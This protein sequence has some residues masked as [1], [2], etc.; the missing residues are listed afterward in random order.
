[1]QTIKMTE[2]NKEF[3]KVYAEK[4]TIGGF[5]N[6][7]KTDLQ[8]NSRLQY[9]MTGVYGELAFYTYRYGSTD[10][11][12]S[13]L[14]YKFE[15]LR[16]KNTGDGGMDDIVEIDGVKKLIDIKTS[17]VTDLNKIQYLNLIIPPREFH[18]N[19]IYVCAFTVGADRLNVDQVVLAGWC[20]SEDVK[21][22]WPIDPVKFCVPF[23]DLRDIKE[24]EK[25]LL[26]EQSKEIS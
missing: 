16:P 18:P 3:V 13:I 20:W 14:D 4:Q 5:S 1:M 7:S 17:H 19:S 15:N 21:K 6:L 26:N 12:K 23:K 2:E 10:K 22:K 9:Q 24:L 11:L 8:K 25:I